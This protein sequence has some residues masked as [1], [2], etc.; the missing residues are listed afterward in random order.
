MRRRVE[1]ARPPNIAPAMQPTTKQDDRLI[2]ILREYLGPLDE[3]ALGVLRRQLSWVE[4]QAGE[5]L[6][7][8][9]EPGD[10]LYISISGRLRAYA[11]DANGEERMLREMARG[12][13]IGEMALFT[14]APRSAT[15]VAI[16]D[17]VLVRLDQAGWN[18]LLQSSPQ[19]SALLTRQALLRLQNPPQGAT[20]ARPVTMALLPVSPGVDAAAFARQLGAAL[21]RH[22]KVCVVDAESVDAALGEPGLARSPMQDRAAGRRIALHLDALEADQD[23]LLL[24]SDAAPGPWT[25]RCAR[26][27]D[28]V[29]L[30]ADTSQPP[31]LHAIEQQLLERLPVRSEPAEI[32]VLMHPAGTHFPRGTAAWLN[33]RPVADHLH[34]RQGD[35]DDMARLARIQSR[36]AVGLVL[37][38]GGARGCAHLGVY[39]ALQEQGVVV[40][41]VGG[42]SIGAAMSML[43]ASGR[44]AAEVTD[45]ARRGFAVNPT[46][47]YRPLPLMSLIAGR[48]LRR[49]LDQAVQQTTG[50]EA[51]AE[52]LWKNWYCI[53]S[54]YSQAREQLLQRGPLGRAIRASVAIPGALPPVLIDGELLCD[55]GSFNNFPVDVMRARRGVGRVI[56]VDLGMRQAR[57]FTQEEV[58]STW[59]LML[60]MLR[61]RRRRQYRFPSLVA[62]LMNVNILYSNSRRSHSHSL[63]DL[64]MNPPL[65]RVGM[66]QWSRFDSIV[67]QGH[68]HAREVLAKADP[69]LLAAWRGGVRPPDAAKAAQPEA[70]LSPV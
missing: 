38:G 53:A 40:D 29:L 58:P 17:S 9:G 18:E 67:E 61:P 26:H 69:A 28:E 25:E 32:L 10:A 52:D 35:G 11:R 1:A 46:S 70:A 43:V 39:R 19:V 20:Q 64:V 63:A 41:F 56:G 21:R 65:Y 33:R 27:A 4:L 13:V 62:Y 68:A 2:R 45:I 42:T 36:T 24:A 7:N 44:P 15:V 22:G 54:N 23:F 30:L 57:R 14:Q 59:A 48:R 51:Q 6:M 16:R 60:D 3:A 8:Q 34:V 55:G 50:F 31:Q 12:Q 5:V 47:D 37:A 66:L 49:L